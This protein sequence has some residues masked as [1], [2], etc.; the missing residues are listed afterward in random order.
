MKDGI[1]DKVGI[2]AQFACLL[3]CIA[4]PVVLVMFPIFAASFWA[5]EFYE[6]IFL[7]ISAILASIS[8]CWGYAK[9]GRMVVFML[10]SV[11]FVCLALG[12]AWERSAIG[13]TTLVVGGLLVI[14]SHVVNW[15]L[16]RSCHT[17]SH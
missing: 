9:H 6:H 5:N 1:L 17:C 3:H 13:L 14:S 7:V 15:R 2:F 12:H 11:G 16:C 8:L 4:T 10:L